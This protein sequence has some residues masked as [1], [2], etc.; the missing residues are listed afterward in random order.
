MWSGPRT[1]SKGVQ[2]PQFCVILVGKLRCEMLAQTR[3]R[4]HS[5]KVSLSRYRAVKFAQ[6]TFA[7]LGTRVEPGPA[8][9]AEPRLLSV[10]QTAISRVA[11]GAL[12]SRGDLMKIRLKWHVCLM[13]ALRGVVDTTRARSFAAAWVNLR[14]SACRGPAAQ[15]RGLAR[16]LSSGERCGRTRKKN[17]K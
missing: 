16:P 17:I 10:R 5:C 6:N 3:H 11:R 12:P 8:G 14:Y 2:T 13:A 4:G 9:L 7:F 1:Y 15:Q